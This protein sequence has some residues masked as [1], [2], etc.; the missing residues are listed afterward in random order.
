MCGRTCC[1]VF[2]GIIIGAAIT[3]AVTYPVL[4]DEWFGPGDDETGARAAFV[5]CSD[6]GT[7]SP[8]D[9]SEGALASGA[10]ILPT[11]AI[12]RNVSLMTL[13]NSARF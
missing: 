7:Q 1:T 10:S 11:N 9:V 3:I 13:A 8:A 6:A 5:A 4:R 12:L 2:T